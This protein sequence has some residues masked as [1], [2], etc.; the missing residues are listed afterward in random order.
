[1]NLTVDEVIQAL[2]C[3]SV[4]TRPSCQE[5]PV[6]EKRGCA[7]QLQALALE[8][9]LNQNKQIKELRGVVDNDL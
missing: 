9:I 4:S 6:G 3:C 2:T 5:C 1:M 8:V 7:I